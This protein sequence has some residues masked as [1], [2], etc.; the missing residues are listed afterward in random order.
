MPPAA[1]ALRRSLSQMTLLR[2]GV[3]NA[4]F[5]FQHAF[6]PARQSG[7][8]DSAAFLP[9]HFTATECFIMRFFPRGSHATLYAIYSSLFMNIL[10]FDREHAKILAT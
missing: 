8:K 3:M 1:A 2:V 7:A 6:N 10:Y 4:L 5:A 9:A